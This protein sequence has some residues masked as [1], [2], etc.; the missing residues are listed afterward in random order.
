VSPA[1]ASEEVQRY[2]VKAT[3]VAARAQ[4]SVA[5]VSLVA[6]DKAAGRVSES[7]VR[8]VRQAIDKPREAWPPADGSAWR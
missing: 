3:D 1:A 6:N 4:V 5:T 7:T 2:R 8:R